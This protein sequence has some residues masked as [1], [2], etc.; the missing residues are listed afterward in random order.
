MHS[1]SYTFLMK[2]CCAPSLVAHSLLL[3]TELNKC[4]DLIFQSIK[5][6][7][8]QLKE[9]KL[10]GPATYNYLT[11]RKENWKSTKRTHTKRIF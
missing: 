5:N 6:W 7:Q 1:S 4:G 3:Y 8:Q 10:E 11:A 2:V 9:L